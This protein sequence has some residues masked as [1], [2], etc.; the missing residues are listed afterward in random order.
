[1]LESFQTIQDELKRLRAE[2]LKSVF[3]SDQ[4]M[5][6]LGEGSTAPNQDDIGVQDARIDLV[7]DDS[8]AQTAVKNTQ[9]KGFSI[10]PIPTEP[11]SFH[12]PDGTASERLAWL[13]NHV[14][15]CPVCNEHLSREGKIVFGN[16]SE[17]ADIFF[18][19]EAPGADEERTGQ[20]FV[21]KAGQLLTK[22]IEAMGLTRDSVY[23]ANIL[24]WRPEHDKPYGN[25]PPTLEEMRFCLP[26]VKAQI[27][28]IKPKAIV[29]LGNTAVQGLLG[30]DPKRRISKSRGTWDQFEK[31]PLMITFHPSYLLRNNTLETKRLVWEDMLKVMEKVALPITE[32]QRSYFLPK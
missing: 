2:G 15:N 19:G 25:R 23:I 7:S 17:T 27:E 6:V 13:D 16:G 12:L 29:A 21:G 30:P 4:T 32:K 20:P 3:V 10:K 31:T 9:P 22:I 1:M 26:Y 18:C 11:A 28:I 14:E 8:R 24:K 5:K